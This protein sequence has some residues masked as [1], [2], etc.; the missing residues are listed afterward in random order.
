MMRGRELERWARGVVMAWWERRHDTKREPLDVV[1]AAAYLQGGI[2]ALA[3]EIRDIEARP[4]PA[5]FAAPIVTGNDS[6]GTAREQ[7]PGGGR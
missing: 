7:N 4:R 2:D 5:Q 1:I 3:E 6:P